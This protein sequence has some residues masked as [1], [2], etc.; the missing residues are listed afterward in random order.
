MYT[1]Q[2]H[3]SLYV[4]FISKK[5][6]PVNKYWTIADDMNAEILRGVYTDTAIYFE[7]HQKLD[8]LMEEWISW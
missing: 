3:I 8:K 6:N 2:L 1:Q 7:M 5:K 4:S